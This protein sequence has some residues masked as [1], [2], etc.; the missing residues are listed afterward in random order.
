MTNHNSMKRVLIAAA[1]FLVA[2]ASFLAIPGRGS[3]PSQDPANQK[4][5]SDD[6]LALRNALKRGG[7]REAAKLKGHCVAEYNPHWDFGQFS[8]E[9]LTK[10]RYS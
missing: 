10:N 4:P 7:L 9:T 6:A 1:I 3:Q 8:V 5:G 2:G